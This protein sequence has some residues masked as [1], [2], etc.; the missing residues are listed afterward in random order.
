MARI[1][2]NAFSTTGTAPAAPARALV[3]PGTLVYLG[4]T[5]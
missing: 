3:S 1:D 2:S 4:L 5:R